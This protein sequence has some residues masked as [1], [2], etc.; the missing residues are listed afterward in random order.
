MTTDQIEKFLVP[1][2]LAKV[3]VKIDFKT[4]NSLIGIFIMTGDYQELKTKNFWRIVTGPNVESWK[5]SQD[6]GLARIFN[7]SEITRLS[8]VK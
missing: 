4:R 2:Y 5:K 7:G 6:N 3:S 8:A 1:K